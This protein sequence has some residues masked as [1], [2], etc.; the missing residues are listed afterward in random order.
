MSDAQPKVTVVTPVYNGEKFLAEAIESVRRQTYANWDYVISDNCSTDRT[1]A[2]AERYARIDPRIRVHAGDTFLPIIANWNRA[3]RQIPPD[4]VYCKV[5]HAD[6]MLMSSCLARMVELMEHHPRVGIVGSYILAGNQ[7][8]GTGLPPD[9]SVWDGVEICRNTLLGHYYLFGS[10][11][12]LL[13][14]ADLV[15]AKPDGFYN[16]DNVHADFEICYELLEHHDFGFVHEVLTYTRK[17]SGSM[18]NA[19][20]RFY[21]PQLV[22]YLGMM[23]KYG[24]KYL[25]RA[26][27]DRVHGEMLR[28]YR[29]VIARRIVA[30]RGRDYWRFHRDKLHRLGYRISGWNIVRAGFE[31]LGRLVLHPA[32]AAQLVRSV[33]AQRRLA[34]DDMVD[35]ARTLRAANYDETAA[36]IGPGR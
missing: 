9:R 24:P 4:A 36:D 1:R 6:D 26:T 25:D 5:L 29:R 31:E 15:R 27:F 30:G 34:A 33:V 7:V 20:S 23:R 17:H 16:E 8:E 21:N 19:F 22:E 18:G 35:R 32:E 10:P 3:L 2:I 11:S 13:L 14:R 28:N 12:S